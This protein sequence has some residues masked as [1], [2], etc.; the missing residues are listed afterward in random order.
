M[1]IMETITR[2]PWP[3]RSFTSDF[4]AEIVGLCEGSQVVMPGFGDQRQLPNCRS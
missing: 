4:K 3:G 2:K 1:A